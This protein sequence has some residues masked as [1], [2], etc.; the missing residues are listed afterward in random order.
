[1]DYY[2][3]LMQARSNLGIQWLGVVL[4]GGVMALETTDGGKRQSIRLQV[5]A[6]R[7]SFNQGWLRL[8][9]SD[10]MGR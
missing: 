8:S 5:F 2:N 1:M 9:A 6:V 10:V 7:L 4:A 3:A